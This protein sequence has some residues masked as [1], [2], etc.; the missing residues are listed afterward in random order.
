[1]KN[2]VVMAIMILSLITSLITFA[3][4]H[5]RTAT[6]Q[7]SADQQIRKRIFYLSDRQIKEAVAAGNVDLPSVTAFRSEQS[8]PVLENSMSGR[9]PA[10]NVNTP[11]YYVVMMSY[12]A[13]SQ[14]QKYTLSD[15]KKISQQFSG[16]GQLGFSVKASG[17]NA[18][19]TDHISI[20]LRQGA[21][22]MEPDSIT[23]KGDTADQDGTGSGR[24]AKIL[25]PYFDTSRI[26]F[27]KPAELIYQDEE[28]NQSA[29]Y[30][31]DFTKIK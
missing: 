5:L 13:F 8:L 27:S 3:Q 26:D 20:T 25:I 24:Y 6:G 28:Q 31:V 23:G 12:Q 9:Q 17:D 21:A 14:G 4:S 1:M 30:E 18:R 19:F 7:G 11:Y 29:T 15:A 16:L 22:I 10:I 2:K